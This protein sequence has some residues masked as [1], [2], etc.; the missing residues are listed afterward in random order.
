MTNEVTPPKLLMN[1]LPQLDINIK[2]FEAIQ[3]HISLNLD[4]VALLYGRDSQEYTESLKKY[5]KLF[6]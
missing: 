3:E 4:R 1:A 5:T 6:F 2:Q